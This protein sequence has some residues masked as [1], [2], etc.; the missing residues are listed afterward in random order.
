MP[1]LGRTDFSAQMP[2]LFNQAVTT[3][4][5]DLSSGGYIPDTMKSLLSQFQSGAQTPDVINQLLGQVKSGLQGQFSAD[6]GPFA[7][8]KKNLLGTSQEA[9]EQNVAAPLKES[10]IKQG[11][12]TSG[13]GYDILS[14]SGLDQAKQQAL[15]GS[16]LDLQGLQNWQ[17]QQ[18]NLQNL[19]LNL[20]NFQQNALLGNQNLGMSL[21]QIQT[22][23]RQQALENAQNLAN[24]QL[25]ANQL[26]GYTQPMQAL[27]Y[28]NQLGADVPQFQD[29]KSET[30]TPPAPTNNWGTIGS[31]LGA[32]VGMIP[33]MQ[34]FAPLL[35]GAGGALGDV[36]SGQPASAGSGAL[37]G[38]GLS[39]VANNAMLNKLLQQNSQPAQPY[40]YLNPALS[41]YQSPFTVANYSNYLRNRSNM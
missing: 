37:L 10:L 6:T 39:N 32:G 16:Q 9:Y 30:Y 17:Q 27:Q 19:G 40:D 3:A 29:I 33:G 34:P 22:A 14:S 24:Q 8:L 21:A 25:S 1:N 38:S 26:L 7:A 23:A 31:L 13:P 2:S 18:Q 28:A 35:A 15:L 4:G 12:Y 20:G 36:L 11:L 5:G 41:G